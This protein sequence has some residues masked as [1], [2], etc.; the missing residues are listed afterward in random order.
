MKFS[1][2][3]TLLTTGL[4]ALNYNPVPPID[5]GPWSI[6]ILQKKYPQS[7]IFCTVGGGA[8][9]TTEELFDRVFISIHAYGNQF[10]Y[11]GA[12]KLAQ[13]IDKILLGVDRVQTVGTTRTLY[14][15]RTGAG[16]D[17]TDYDDANR[18]RFSC[19][20]LAESA[21]GL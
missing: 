11:A 15:V 8:G 16:P 3:Q 5:P 12:E 19:T 13:D 14:I 20:Y 1:D 2:V 18:Y 17:L 9:L 6:A 4:T 10:D 7:F 21:T